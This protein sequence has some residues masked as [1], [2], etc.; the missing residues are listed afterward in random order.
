MSRP[1][2]DLLDGQCYPH[3]FEAA[4][5]GT[6]ENSTGVIFC[7][8]CGEIRALEVQRIAA[9]VQEMLTTADRTDAQRIGRD[10]GEPT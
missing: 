1:P 4:W 9:P 8:K 6:D 7:K 10:Y 5:Q 3:W 2:I